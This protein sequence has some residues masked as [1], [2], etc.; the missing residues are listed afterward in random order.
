VKLA[1]PR[2]SYVNPNIPKDL[3]SAREKKEAIHFSK[4]PFSIIYEILM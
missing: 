4:K 2:A 1:S 3:F